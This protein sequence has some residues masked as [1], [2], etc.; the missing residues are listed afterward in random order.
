MNARKYDPL[1]R[2]VDDDCDCELTID[3]EHMPLLV[4]SWFG[5][6]SMALAEAYQEWF[7]DFVERGEVSGRRFVVLDDASR[8]GRPT[9]TVRGCLSKIE[10]PPALVLARIVVVDSAG[11]RGAITALTWST[12]KP[13][14]TVPTMEAGVREC[15]ERLDAAGLPRPRNFDLSD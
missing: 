3:T 9:P 15:F 5:S 13:I 12:G 7:A 4:T 8:A 11:I 10:C 14:K 2:V 1:I 6:P